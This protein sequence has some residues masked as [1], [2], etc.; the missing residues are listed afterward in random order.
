[1][2]LTIEHNVQSISHCD[3]FWKVL[4]SVV[5]DPGAV[6]AY[7]YEVLDCLL[8]TGESFQLEASG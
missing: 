5:Q 2:S 3:S 7:S 8:T 4:G 6:V 1:M